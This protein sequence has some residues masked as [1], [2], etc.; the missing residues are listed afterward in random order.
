M[1]VLLSRAVFVAGVFTAGADLKFTLKNDHVRRSE[2]SKLS[3]PKSPVFATKAT[4]RTE[5]KVK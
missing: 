4:L 3:N 1:H 5:I 2:K